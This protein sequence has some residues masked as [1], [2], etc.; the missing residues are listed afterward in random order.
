MNQQEIDENNL[1]KIEE[2]FGDVFFSMVN[3]A[4]FLDV[5]PEDALERTNKKFIRRFQYL[6]EQAS[7]Q[8]RN[9]KDMSLSEMNEIWEKAKR[10]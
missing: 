7:K 4:R 2:E 5:N 10:L 9:L 3:Y 1:E 6:E 8:K